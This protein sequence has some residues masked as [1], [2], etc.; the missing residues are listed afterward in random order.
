MSALFHWTL[1]LGWKMFDEITMILPLWIGIQSMMFI[2]FKDTRE[3]MRRNLFILN[4]SNVALIVLNSFENFQSLFPILFSIEMF[5][6]HHVYVEL[7][8]KYIDHHNVGERGVQICAISGF[9]WWITEKFLCHK[10]F[11]FGHLLWHI[12]MPIGV[13]YILQ[14]TIYIYTKF[15]PR[16]LHIV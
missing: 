8:K 16:L 2:L 9:M 15:H 5:Y 1:I 11:I 4:T 7:Q 14:Y 13:D 3:I 12:G 10:Y 6:L